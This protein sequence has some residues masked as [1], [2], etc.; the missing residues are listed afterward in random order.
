MTI[1]LTAKAWLLQQSHLKMKMPDNEVK[2]AIIITAGTKILDILSVK[3]ELDWSVT[4]LSFLTK[5]TIWAS[6]V[7]EPTLVALK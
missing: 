1:T 2:I 3:F 6:I 7:S 4:S 5:S